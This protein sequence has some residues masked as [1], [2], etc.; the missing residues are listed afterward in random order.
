MTLL[1]PPCTVAQ[2]GQAVSGLGEEITDTAPLTL[3]LWDT[4]RVRYGFVS[5]RNRSYS[6]SRPIAINDKRT[7]LLR[8]LGSWSDTE[9]VDE[10]Q[11]DAIGMFVQAFS[12]GV[13]KD[14]MGCDLTP[15]IDTSHLFTTM[16]LPSTEDFFATGCLEA[17]Q[18]IRTGGYAVAVRSAFAVHFARRAGFDSS[19][20]A[21]LKGFIEHGVRCDVFWHTEQIYPDRIHTP[22]NQLLGGRPI[23]IGVL[24]PSTVPSLEDYKVYE[25]I[26]HTFLRGPAGAVALLR[27]GILWRL[28]IG[29]RGLQSSI[30][31]L[32]CYR[33]GDLSLV[34]ITTTSD[35]YS[36][37]HRTLSMQEEYI[38]CGAYRVLTRKSKMLLPVVPGQ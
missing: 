7:Y 15:Y 6:S 5:G 16:T 9:E 3:N 27:G 8:T 2:L 24:Q 30:P 34:T 31:D 26:R 18:A 1:P 4:L 25:R 11:M 38:I 17:R 21:A 36:V 32:T 22:P 20:A 33:N 29:S 13:P 35:N 23:G 14:V 37:V 28:T 12:E 10:E 19:P